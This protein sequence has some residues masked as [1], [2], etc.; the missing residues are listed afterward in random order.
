MKVFGL[1]MPVFVFND[2]SKMGYVRKNLRL[3][4]ISILGEKWAVRSIVKYSRIY[5]INSMEDLVKKYGL[6]KFGDYYYRWEVSG[7]EILGYVIKKIGNRIM[8]AAEI[9]TVVS[10]TSQPHIEHNLWVDVEFWDIEDRLKELNKQW[11]VA[12][13]KIKE[14]RMK[15]KME[16][17]NEDF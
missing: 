9:N 7:V 12:I 2:F 4:K 10:M 8:M 1:K 15:E 13:M 6:I 5:Y 16:R 11:N 14:Y 3:E 17:I